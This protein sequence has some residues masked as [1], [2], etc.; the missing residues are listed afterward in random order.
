[1]ILSRIEI[2]SQI[3]DGR[4][5][6]EPYYPAQLGTN[7]YDLHLGRNMYSVQGECFDAREDL[8]DLYKPFTIPEDGIWLFPGILYLGV[9]V[10]YT[11]T[12]CFVPVMEGKS[13]LARMGLVP[14]LCAGLGDEGFCGHW[15]LEITVTVPTKVYVGMPIGQ[16]VYHPVYGSLGKNYSETGSYNNRRDP[17]PKP[18]LPNLHLKPHQFIPVV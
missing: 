14:H 4:I 6:I 5:V 3:E 12:R 7:S 13:S 2:Q 10:E 15:T 16:I 1:M 9:T 17:D 18:T 8:T 11:E